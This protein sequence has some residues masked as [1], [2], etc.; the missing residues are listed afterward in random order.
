MST[1]SSPGCIVLLTAILKTNL[2]KNR[3]T[4]FI[5]NPFSPLPELHGSC[6]VL[7]TISIL[8][9]L[10]F[11]FKMPATTRNMLQLTE[12]MF[13]SDEFS[14]I[15]YVLCTYCEDLSECLRVQSTLK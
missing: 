14:G 15:N 4:A 7:D 13:L 5:P 6:L 10:P 12:M 2:L 11:A 8:N 9:Y 1:F 3:L